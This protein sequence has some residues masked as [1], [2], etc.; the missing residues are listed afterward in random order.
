[1]W[2]TR[3]YRYEDRENEVDKNDIRYPSAAASTN[4]PRAQNTRHRRTRKRTVLAIGGGLCVLALVAALV[5]IIVILVLQKEGKSH[6]FTIN[7]WPHPEK[8]F[9]RGFRPGPTQTGLYSF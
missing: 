2:N 4:E 1:M 6:S 8:I 3:R 7:N 9:L 5:P